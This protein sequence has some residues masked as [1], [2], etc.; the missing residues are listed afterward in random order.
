MQSCYVAPTTSNINCIFVGHLLTFTSK[1][2]KR[3]SRKEEFAIH[4]LGISRSL[5]ITQQIRVLDQE[6]IILLVINIWQCEHT[7]IWTLEWSDQCQQIMIAISFG[8]IWHILELINKTCKSYKCWY[9]HINW[10]AMQWTE[11]IFWVRESIGDITR[12]NYKKL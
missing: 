6:F 2:W 11:P 7:N 9:D 4:Q 5:Q 1:H 10:I 3:E 12:W 8:N